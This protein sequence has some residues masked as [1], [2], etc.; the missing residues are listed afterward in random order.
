MLN[1]CNKLISLIVRLKNIKR[2]LNIRFLYNYK[3]EDA[4]NF[5]IIKKKL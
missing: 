2:K 5:K 4:L 3:I 1:K